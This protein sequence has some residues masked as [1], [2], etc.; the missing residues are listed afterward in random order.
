ATF[1]KHRTRLSQPPKPSPNLPCPG[2]P[3]VAKISANDINKPAR[4]ASR[5][6]SPAGCPP[7]ADQRQLQMISE[8]GPIVCKINLDCNLKATG[9]PTGACTRT[10]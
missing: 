4:G 7:P 2:V 3:S 6:S 9:V 5:C 1:T 10:R 8:S